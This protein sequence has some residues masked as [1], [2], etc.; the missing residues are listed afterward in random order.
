M[1]FQFKQAGCV[2][3]VL[4]GILISQA[5]GE[6]DDPWER[7]VPPPD[8]KFDWLQLTSGEWL[9]GDFKV[10]YAH[11]LEFDSDEMDLQT[12][13]FED[14]KRLRTRNR[15]NVLVERKG[16][17]GTIVRRGL[18]E[19][20]DGQVVVLDTEERFEV[21]RKRVVAIASGR[22]RWWDM[23]S[24][25]LS[26]G[27][28]KRSGNTETTDQTVMVG[29]KR[30]TA[31]SQLLIDYLANYSESNGDKTTDNQRLTS[32]Y[33]WFL[34]SRFYWRILQGEYYSDEFTNID[35][36]YSIGSG[37]GYDLIRTSRTEWSIYSGLGYQ[38]KEFES[39]EA[40]EDT[41]ST[42]AFFASGLYFDQDITSRVDFLV[43][44]SMRWLN[45]ENGRYTHHTVATL[46]IDLIN[47][48]D[49]DLSYIWDRVE[50][51]QR[52]SGGD[53]P[54]KDDFQ[55]VVSITYEF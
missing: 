28:N 5:S 9:K 1:M 41:S 16:G 30:R 14:V 10:M 23:W 39:V 21:E 54:D 18:L 37:P 7:F 43:D 3:G 13:D 45:D 33:S 40:G 22:R 19:I 25:S 49:I 4:L 50:S 27:L 36:E 12:F 55:Y 44:Y 8:K 11:E 42:S 52:S 17:Q 48:F 24:G 32:S 47:D 20:T 38:K 29:L 53:L 2:A 31:R 15:Q 6:P 34:T 35:N 51:P 46:S 26:Y